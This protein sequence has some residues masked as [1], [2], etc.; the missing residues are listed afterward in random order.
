[1]VKFI[2]Y[3]VAVIL[4][5]LIAVALYPI[6]AICWIFSVIGKASSLLF[7]WT[8]RTIKG[9]WADINASRVPPV[10]LPIAQD[11]TVEGVPVEEKEE[12]KL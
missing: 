2:S 4:T 7:N 12:I 11:S 10:V 1:M 8:N 5:A 3:I 6:C 9:L